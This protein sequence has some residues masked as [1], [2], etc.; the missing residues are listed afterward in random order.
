MKKL[1][2]I[3]LAGTIFA[4]GTLAFATPSTIEI[5]NLIAQGNWQRAHNK[6]I[7]VLHEH[8]NSTYAHYLYGQ[9]LAREGRA[10]D[11]LSELQKARELDP[12]LRFS[13]STKQFNAIEEYVRREA[14][15][16]AKSNETSLFTRMKWN[17]PS[18]SVWI[19]F[20]SVLILVIFLVRRTVLS[21]RSNYMSV[22]QEH[23]RTQLK[24]M[25]ELLNVTRSLRL[26]V[27]LSM[28]DKDGALLSEVD[29][30]ESRLC[31][32]I[33]KLT[34][35]NS[36]V[37]DHTL[38]H[39]ESRLK[40]VQDYSKTRRDLSV[41]DNQAISGTQ[42]FSSRDQVSVDAQAACIIQAQDNIARQSMQ[43]Q[44]T[45]VVQQSE[46]SG[47]GMG[48]LLTGM[49]IGQIIGNSVE[50]VI[51]DDRHRSNYLDAPLNPRFDTWNSN[52]D[53]DDSKIVDIDVGDNGDSEW[54]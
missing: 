19:G 31:E 22:Q 28:K 52:D 37:P 20:I 7:Q 39:L 40:I 38:E 8:P 3:I 24:R 11:A 25:T 27:R 54:T 18:I 21:A 29:S 23:R 14:Q 16:A 44:S 13:S 41:V 35:T 15:R 48:G 45:L 42:S 1:L 26:D 46:D 34:N 6:L 12:E 10:S 4:A 32:L 51:V 17:N 5:N 47:R 30:I 43:P 50:R 36:L 2:S 33:D 49:L 53:W 9:V